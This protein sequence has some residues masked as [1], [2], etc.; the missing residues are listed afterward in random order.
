MMRHLVILWWYYEDVIGSLLCEFLYIGG[1]NK[2]AMILLEAAS[3]VSAAWSCDL[4]R[5]MQFC[6][7][8]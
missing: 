3:F 8:Y 4:S 7:L 1:P 6:S 5:V 2:G